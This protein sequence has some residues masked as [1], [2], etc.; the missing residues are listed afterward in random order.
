M[1]EEYISA[2]TGAQMDDALTQM[3][4]RIPEGWAVGEKDGVPVPSSSQ[5]YRNNAKFY[6]EQAG[7]AITNIGAYTTRAENAATRAEAGATRAE[8]AA[9]QA[10]GSET[11]AA[12]SASSAALAEQ[13]AWDAAH[14]IT[15]GGGGSNPN[16]LY[17]P[18]FTIDTFGITDYPADGSKL[19]MT[20]VMEGWKLYSWNGMLFKRT[21]NGVAFGMNTS[22]TSTI[23]AFLAQVAPYTKYPILGKTFTASIKFGDG[24]IVSGTKVVDENYVS[25][26]SYFTTEIDGETIECSVRW[27]NNSC[28][29]TIAL[30]T[31][32]ANKYIEIQACKLEY[33]D[34]ST[35]SLDGPP[36]YVTELA[37]C[38]SFFRHFTSDLSTPVATG[39]VGED[40][41]LTVILPYS[42]QTVTPIK[43]GLFANGSS[44]YNIFKIV[45]QTA[46][47]IATLDSPG[48]P[49]TITNTGTS[50]ILKWRASLTHEFLP[51]S[52]IALYPRGTNFLNTAL[53]P[54]YQ[55]S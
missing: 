55:V 11:R 18:F 53:Y 13:S 30:K 54:T 20:Y 24:T 52:P 50:L 14:S 48:G 1:A 26:P 29:F 25:N 21:N 42:M 49:S 33:G 44:S 43:W 9:T 5:F 19:F 3:N 45:G 7:A 46:N 47:G 51:L 17:N 34:R 31:Y 37:R 28:E 39:I 8:A 16:L 27:G 38:Q 15:P 22:G 6:A 35:L 12:A 36:D 32:T 10:S 23:G 41:V 4:N 40:G 2:L